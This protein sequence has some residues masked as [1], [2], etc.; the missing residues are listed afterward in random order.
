VSFDSHSSIIKKSQKTPKNEIRK[1]GVGGGMLAIV[2]NKMAIAVYSSPLG[3]SGN[4]V[5]G[6]LVIQELS[7][8]WNL[9]MLAGEY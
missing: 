4:S 1:S 5:R 2:P 7:K 3:S 6:Q 9:H 8:L